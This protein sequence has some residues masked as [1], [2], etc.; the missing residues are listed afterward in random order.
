VMGQWWQYGDSRQVRL[1]GGDV[2]DSPE[3][4]RLTAMIGR[5][6]SP[7]STWLSCMMD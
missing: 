1:G 2:R 4:D 3:G 7:R 6:P 5:H